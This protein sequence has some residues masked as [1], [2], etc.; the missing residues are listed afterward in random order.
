VLKMIMQATQRFEPENRLT[1]ERLWRRFRQAGRAW[2]KVRIQSKKGYLKEPPCSHS[3]TL[4]KVF[5]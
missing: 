3:Y 5:P 4:Y 2:V 1:A